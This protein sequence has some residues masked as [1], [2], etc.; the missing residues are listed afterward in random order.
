MGGNI[1]INIIAWFS[2]RQ[3][4]LPESPGGITLRVSYCR[5]CNKE[6]TRHP[7]IV[8]ELSTPDEIEEARQA[9]RRD[10]E[11]FFGHLY[12]VHRDLFGENPDAPTFIDS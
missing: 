11:I 8:A 7:P 2:P 10:G 9:S 3:V 1:E 6:I 5:V 4:D 12:T